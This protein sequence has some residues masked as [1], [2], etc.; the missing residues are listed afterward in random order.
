MR[1]G[2][3]MV[4]MNAK[5]FG[6]GR[7]FPHDIGGSSY[8]MSN[9]PL[10]GYHGDDIAEL[11]ELRNSHGRG[12]FHERWID[13]A[14]NPNGFSNIYIYE[15]GNSA[16]VGLNSR[17]DSG[18]DERTPV[19]TEF[20]PNTIL[21]ELTGNAADPVIDP[22]NNIPDAIQINASGQAT[23]RVPRNKTGSTEHGKGYVIYGLATPQGTLSI[24]NVSEVLEGIATP[25]QATNGTA[26]L[27]DIDVITANSF[28]VQLNTTPVTLPAPFAV[29]DVHADGDLAMLRIDDGMDLNGSGDIDNVDLTASAYGFEDFTDTNSPG[30][31]WNGTTNIGTGSGTYVQ[32]IDTTEL[33]EGRHYLT[34]RAFRHRKSSTGGDGGPAVF[35]DFRRTF[36]VDRLPPEAAIVS[37]EPFA[38]DPGNPNNRDL[39]VRSVDKTADNMHFLIDLPASLSE[40]QIL[41]LVTGSNQAGYYDRD[42][43]IRGYSGVSSGNHVVTV[44][45]YE[46][47][48][49][50]NI[51]RFPGQFTDTNIGLGFGDLNSSGAFTVSDIRCS[52]GSGACGNNSAEDILYSQNTKFRAAFDVNG[53]GLGDNR[54]L[55]A[56]GDELVSGGAGQTVLDAYT[57]LLL[58]RA[59]VDS[60]ASSNAADVAAVYASFGSPSW[61]TD[62][63]VDG[64]VDIDD[65]SAMITELFRTVPGDFTLDGVVDA[66]DYV[67][68]RKG[69]GSVDALFTQGDADFDRDVDNDDLALWQLNFGF[70]RQPLTAGGG[71]AAG[72]PEPHVL[73]LVVLA[74][75]WTV[76]SRRFDRRAV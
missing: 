49:N 6:E 32:T 70:V 29:R 73:W 42:Q 19:S 50:Y 23:I 54:D 48:G 33:S 30:Y 56:L 76:N 68:A 20:A 14:F 11:V 61:L 9:D 66:G 51:Q 44:V 41:A 53:D 36:Y 1:P 8:S 18:Y 38:S 55:F 31:V 58:Q 37:F 52:S 59:D 10:G 43:F 25:T 17:L 5:E 62:I 74:A 26:R 75:C 24:S 3:A 16:I 2:E 12:N 45:S 28:S 34:V 27:A 69:V 39:I 35:T 57:G 64:A 71:G 67:V 21:V 65:V 4:Y 47:T 40:A 63:N 22:S 15:R 60:S 72:V 46:P 13:D 7:A